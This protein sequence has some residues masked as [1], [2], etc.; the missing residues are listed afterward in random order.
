MDNRIGELRRENKLTLKQLGAI[1]KVKDNTLSQYETGKRNPTLGLL[2]EIANFFNVSLEYLLM[3]SDIRD[4][5]FE[6][7]DKN[8]ELEAISLLEKLESNEISSHDL[9]KKTS[10]YLSK[11]IVENTDILEK[12]KYN[13]LYSE[14]YSFVK[15][16]LSSDRAIAINAQMRESD[17]ELLKIITSK[18]EDEEY[19]GVTL[20]EVL[21]FI[22]N[23]ERISM[24]DLDKV[25]DFMESMPTEHYD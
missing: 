22:E 14:A 12:D 21:F 9:S 18:L 11:W 24:D 13:H 17:Y 7:D 25:M 1:L 16:F 23:A 4:Y 15:D 6:E 2:F 5:T 3:K 20:K 10:L 8:K 19:N